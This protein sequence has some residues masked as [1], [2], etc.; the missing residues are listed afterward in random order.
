MI[1][2][3]CAPRSGLRRRIAEGSLEGGRLPA[4]LRHI[5]S[6][7][8]YWTLIAVGADVLTAAETLVGA[9]PIRSLDA[10]HVASAQIFAA[11]LSMPG[12]LFVS[13]DRRQTD[14]AAA[15]GL[16]VQIVRARG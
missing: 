3:A 8:R 4:I 6:D 12:L 10:I 1:V 5:A 9:H 2:G 7:R 15:V 16:A 13:A 14:T 11:R